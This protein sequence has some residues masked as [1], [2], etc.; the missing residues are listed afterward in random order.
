MRKVLFIGM[1]GFALLIAGVALAGARWDFSMEGDGKET[2]IDFLPIPLILVGLPVTVIAL[3]IGVITVLTKV[4]HSR[5]SR[6]GEAEPRYGL[7]VAIFFVA[8]FAC[9]VIL[10]L[11]S[12]M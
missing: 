1:G 6:P 11:A 7:I 3:P 4:A 10:Y 2:W 8:S 12:K 9:L 5:L